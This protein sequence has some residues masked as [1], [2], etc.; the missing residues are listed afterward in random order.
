MI[1]IDQVLKEYQSGKSIPMIANTLR[2]SQWS[3]YSLLKRN[4]ILRRSSAESNRLRFLSRPLSFEK[5]L[6]LNEAEQKLNLLG[7]TLY[8]AEGSKRGRST[9]DF[10]N[11]DPLMIKVFLNFL[12]RIYRVSEERLRA[13]LYC[14]S[15]QTVDSLLDYWVKLTNIPKH[16]FT[17]P[18][19]RQDFRADKDGRM[20]SGLLH[21]RYNDTR[22][23]AQIKQ[24]IETLTNDIQ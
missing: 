4:R 1:N 22:L 17:K 3:L 15:N 20:P 12:R 14:H 16:Q 19:I 11:S 9:V 10:A 5:K 8:W 13:L 6:S 23:L 18:Y 7:L 2:V 24:D 21:I